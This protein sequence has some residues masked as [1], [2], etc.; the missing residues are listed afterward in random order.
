MQLNL[1]SPEHNTVFILPVDSVVGVATTAEVAE[2]EAIT[3]AVEVDVA[4]DVDMM[5]EVIHGRATAAEVEVDI[6]MAITR[7]IHFLHGMEGK[8][9]AMGEGRNEAL[10]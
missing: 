10:R 1:F 9:I 2:E 7:E 5:T 4:V 8:E 6:Q 3:T